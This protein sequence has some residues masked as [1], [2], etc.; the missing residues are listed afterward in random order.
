MTKHPPKN[1]A[2][3][4]TVPTRQPSVG[5][6]RRPAQ[7][8]PE[9]GQT[10][11][12]YRYD[13]FQNRPPA[14]PLKASSKRK[15]SKKKIALLILLPFILLGLWLGGKFSYDL[16]KIFKGNVFGVLHSSRLKGESDGR[17]NILIAGNSADDIGHNGGNL[18]DSIMILSVD[19]VH[20][21]ALLLS[22]PR[23]LYVSIP[24]NGHGKINQAYVDG[25]N[26]KF[27]QD[28]YPDGGMG[29]LE[30]TIEQTLGI[31]SQY[32]ALI[33][34]TALRDMVNAVG[35]IDVNIQSTDRRGL[36]DP[37]RDYAT[38]G[39]LVHLSNG[40]HHLDGEQAL[41]LARA[42]G[43]ARGSYGYGN[44]DFT[45]TANQRLMLLALKNKAS[46]TGVLAN[47]V[48]LTSLAD[49][50]GNNV[51]S[52]MSVSEVRR[53]YDLMKQIS[54][55]KV[56]SAG[57]NDLNGANYLTSSRVNGQSI[58]IPADGKDNYGDIRSALSRLFSNNQIVNE[59]AQVVVLN[60]TDSFGVASATKEK[61]VAKFVNVTD[62]ADARATSSTSQII[63]ASNGQDPQTLLLLR[64][65]FGNRVTTVNTYAARYPHATFIVLVGADHIP[66]DLQ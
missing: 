6:R 45:R 27:R 33:N 51:K 63:D 43:D 41:D 5:V 50:L 64:R 23:D 62:I 53:L 42:R 21:K 44:S 8:F 58:L 29:L 56:A 30:K 17:V 36:Y 48:K 15:W 25:E 46:S 49:A 20:H 32:Y 59:G 1:L 57:L 10:L 52:D 37:S 4:S 54:N 61:L 28:G 35:G 11:S 2:L 40:V 65:S 16:A 60:A 24:G 18:T 39:V 7:K 13:A 55:S 19:T 34:Y 38:G 31:K 47:P 26:Q 66:A 3:D 9:V 14:R 12:T 22:V